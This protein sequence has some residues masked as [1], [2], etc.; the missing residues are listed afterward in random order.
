MLETFSDSLFLPAALLAVF[1]WVVPKVLAAALPEG[2]PALA[3]NA[4]L[5]AVILCV[6]SGM[7]FMALYFAQGADPAAFWAEGWA[8]N[9]LFF[10]RL[11]VSAAI[12]WGPILI[13]S[14]ANLPRHWVTKTW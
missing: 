11:G 8:A 3:L 9:A 12:V 5:S 13:L 14:V 1:A 2:V 6:A 10:G 4:I 7:L